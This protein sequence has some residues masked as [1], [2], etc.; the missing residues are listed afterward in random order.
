MAL[1]TC[2]GTE[3][4]TPTE[5][6]AVTVESLEEGVSTQPPKNGGK[7]V[8]WK[9]K[10][11]FCVI[12]C[13]A[14]L[15]WNFI[16][17]ELG[18]L[19]DAFGGPY[20]TW[21]SLCYS[22]CVN[23]G[24]LMLVWI[25]NR[26]KFGPRFYTGCTGMGIS[27]I[28]IAICAITFARTNHAAGFAAGCVLIGVFGF[29]NSLMQSSMFGLAAL[30]DPVCTEFVLIGEGLSGLIAWPLDRLCQAILEG[31]GVTDYVYSRMVFFYGLGMLA[32]FATIPMY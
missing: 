20:G 15:G 18:T 19:I 5:A 2:F 12:G 7:V 22:L 32:N 10:A 17:G 6:D 21:M 29:A 25:G 31:C 13:V 1:F 16:L 11:M 27:M 26:F 23:A 4:P 28:L 30:V 14:L 3:K 9:L 8:D 24:Q